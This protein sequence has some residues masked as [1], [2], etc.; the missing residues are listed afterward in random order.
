[1]LST[2][3][4][5]AYGRAVDSLVTLAQND[6]RTLWSHA[7]RQRPEQARDLLL[8][9]MPALVDQYGSAAAA[10]A[11]EWYRDMRLDQNIPG[12]AP[13]VQTS[14][15]PQGEIDDSVRFGAGALYAGNPDIALSYLTGALIRYVSDGARSQIADMTWADPEAMGWERRTRNPQA[16]NF[17][18]MLT[19]NECY[20]RSQGTASFGAHDN[21]KCVAVPAWDPTSRE[22]PAKAYTLAARH[23]TEKGRKRHRELVSSWIDTHQEELA[24]WRTRPI[25]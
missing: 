3:E 5:G 16:C 15:A 22:V 17:C 10:I 20:Y 7:A 23:K 9:I 13:T 4:I 21:C 1:M 24:E 8:E 6:L 14:L 12:D 25:E 18:V 2:A 11:D 19:M